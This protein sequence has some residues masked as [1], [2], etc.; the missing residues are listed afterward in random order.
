MFHIIS[1]WCW[2]IN[3]TNSFFKYCIARKNSFIVSSAQWPFISLNSTGFWVGGTE[4]TSGIWG[5]SIVGGT[6][7]ITSPRFGLNQEELLNLANNID[8]VINKDYKGNLYKGNVWVS[9]MHNHNDEEKVYLEDDAN[10]ILYEIEKEV[11]NGKSLLYGV[12]ADNNTPD[13]ITDDVFVG[14]FL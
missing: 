4:G 14:L 5:F 2:A 8:I 9:T 6:G 3:L 13:D 7:D 10:N 12:W 1:I 11:I